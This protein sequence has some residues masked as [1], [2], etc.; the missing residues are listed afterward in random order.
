MVF[1]YIT[2]PKNQSELFGEMIPKA[3]KRKV[4][5]KMFSG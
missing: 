5:K 2:L 4:K 1:Y 3:G